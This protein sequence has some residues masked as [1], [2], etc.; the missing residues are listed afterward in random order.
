MKLKTL[1]VIAV[2]GL[3]VTMLPS[4]YG[5]QKQW[6]EDFTL[7]IGTKTAVPCG[8]S[9]PTRKYYKVWNL[10]ESHTVYMATWSITQADLQAG[11]NIGIGSVKVASGIPL[12]I[13]GTV[14]SMWTDDFNIYPSTWFFLVSS[15]TALGDV[16]PVKALITYRQRK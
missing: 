7:G 16:T 13:A 6:V 8:L 12:T 14:G 9:V 2:L 1:A 15:A 4:A 10:S 5:Q 3:I 11:L